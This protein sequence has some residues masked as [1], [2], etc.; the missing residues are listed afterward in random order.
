MSRKLF[1]LII[2]IFFVS[3][4]KKEISHYPQILGMILNQYPIFVNTS[5]TD[6]KILL[7]SRGKTF[8]LII[9]D[10]CTSELDRVDSSDFSQ[11]SLS[12][13]PNG[14]ELVFQEY[15]PKSYKFDLYVLDITS[16]K[17]YLIKLPASNNAIPPIRWSQS[18][19]YLTYLASTETGSTL[20]V[21]D[22]E[23]EKT[24]MSFEGLSPYSDFRWYKDSILYFNEDPKK[25]ILKEVNVYTDK[26]QNHKLENIDETKKFSIKKGKA[27]I[28][29]R[30]NN[31]EYFQCYEIDLRS[32]K[33]I[34]L[35]NGYFNVSDCIY[36][37]YDSYYFYTKNIQGLN[38]LYCSN[39]AVNNALLDITENE[40]GITLDLEEERNIYL[41]YY[42]LNF[43]PRSVRFD[44]ETNHKEIIY[45]PP[46]V[47]R[48]KL[49]SPKFLDIKNKASNSPIRAFFWQ[50]DSS[51]GISKKT[52]LYVHGGPYLQIRP[53]W[54]IGAKILNRYG[55]N[56]V[57]INYSGSSGYSKEFAEQNDIPH[58]ISDITAS[59]GFL[60]QRYGIEENDII[61]M[62][63]SYGGKLVT[64]AIDYL[65]DIGG[66]VL[67]SG[68]MDAFPSE[69]LKEV[70]LLGF[71]GELD[72]LTS[73]V[74]SII[75][76]SDLH[77]SREAHFKFYENEGHLFHKSSTWA[78]IYSDIV[79]I[80][81]L[82]QE[83]GKR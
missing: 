11:L 43:P 76:K 19:K 34:R 44:L 54:N 32:E 83:T 24:K 18:G 62:G 2:I 28:V 7:K 48:L 78:E 71:Y 65:N 64:R 27:L 39:Q 26:I 46:Y 22:F 5:S 36:S 82:N 13:H 38:K 57:A 8:D 77:Y 15:N 31:E 59:I 52:I 45:E 72:P 60:K 55:F 10:I 9:L 42:S 41:S 47:D 80:Y 4:T 56:L 35:T 6:N 20:F 74:R 12:W 69:K 23:K 67:V 79:H 1:C 51:N 33:I 29:G 14:K 25:P 58:Q 21:Y 66:I 75:D 61:L 81:S 30:E 49:S 17:R 70:K 37:K 40:D 68:D 3:C 73:K 63:S 53:I 16:K 50:S